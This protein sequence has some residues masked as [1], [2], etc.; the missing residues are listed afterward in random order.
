MFDL[1]RTLEWLGSRSVRA[2]CVAIALVACASLNIA[3]VDPGDIFSISAPVIGAEAAK[4][5]PDLLHWRV[6]GALRTGLSAQEAR[7]YRP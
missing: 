4:A 6:K 2:F 7:G 1:T 3:R 5:T